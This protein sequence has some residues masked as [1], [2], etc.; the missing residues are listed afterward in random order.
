MN[1]LHN[2][3]NVN[4]LVHRRQAH[5]LNFSYHRAQDDQF[6]KEGNRELRRY[7][8]PIMKEPKS[9]NKSFERSMLYQCGKNWNELPIPERNI[10]SIKEFKKKQKCKLN[11][12]LPY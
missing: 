5:L 3:C 7:D 2:T 11:Q 8:A 12:L 6:L 4:K 9:N 1:D 10:Q